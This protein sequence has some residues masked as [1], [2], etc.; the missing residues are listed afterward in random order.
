MWAPHCT[1]QLPSAVPARNNEGEIYVFVWS[2]KELNTYFLCNHTINT[3]IQVIDN[4]LLKKKKLLKKTFVSI[5]Y[6]TTTPSHRSIGPSCII[7]S[8]AHYSDIP[9]YKPTIK[10]V[11]ISN[12]NEFISSL[13]SRTTHTPQPLQKN[14]I[15]KK[16]RSMDTPICLNNKWLH[17]R[18][19]YQRSK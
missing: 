5:M 12:K 2:I 19:I 17:H 11:E 10:N 16:I 1:I 13:T 9:N 18:I 14:Y 4:R 15:F 7:I 8:L 6:K 3:F